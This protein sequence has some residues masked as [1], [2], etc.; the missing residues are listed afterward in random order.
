M[1]CLSTEAVFGGVAR[2]EQ[3]GKITDRAGDSRPVTG[4]FD[5]IISSPDVD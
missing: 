4:S 5:V 2:S 3:D 1:S